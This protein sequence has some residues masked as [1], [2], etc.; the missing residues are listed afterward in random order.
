MCEMIRSYFGALTI[1]QCS[2]LINKI[3]LHAMCGFDWTSELLGVILKASHPPVG[4][5]PVGFKTLEL[6]S[7]GAEGHEFPDTQCHEFPKAPP[8][9]LDLRFFEAFL[10]FRKTAPSRIN[11]CRCA[12]LM[13]GT[14]SFCSSHSTKERSSRPPAS[15][16]ETSNRSSRLMDVAIAFTSDGLRMLPVAE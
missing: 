2:N 8:C 9:V 15:S 16:S 5:L 11:R 1:D 6:W 12:R 3:S 13:G 14:S 7:F 10:E 4:S